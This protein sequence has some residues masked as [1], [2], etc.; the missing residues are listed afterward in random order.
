MKNEI[1]FTCRDFDEKKDADKELFEVSVIEKTESEVWAEYRQE[2]REKKME[3]LH[4]SLTILL[5]NKIYPQR[6]EEYHYRIGK[7]DFW[8]S[9]G[10]FI[11][12]QTKKTGRGVFK[13]IELI[14][15]Q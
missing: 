11:N 2:R 12:R 3:N 13:L 6:L 10:K 7:F 14:N 5:K 1:K 4:S 9:T 15:K 8:P